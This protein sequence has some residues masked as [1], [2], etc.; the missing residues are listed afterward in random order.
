[1]T[2]CSKPTY[3]R[4][5]IRKRFSKDRARKGQLPHGMDLNVNLPWASD[6]AWQRAFVVPGGVPEPWGHSTSKA[7]LEVK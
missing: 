4:Q 3:C 2:E 5:S 7:S 1:M 6:T